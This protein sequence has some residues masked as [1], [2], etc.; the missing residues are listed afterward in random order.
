IDPVWPVG[1]P[2]LIVDDRAPQMADRDARVREA[3]ADLMRPF[4]LERGP[5][6]RAQLLR[7]D[8]DE[9]VLLVAMHHAISDEISVRVLIDQLARRYAGEAAPEPLAIQYADYAAWQR[10]WLTGAELDRQ[11]AYWTQHLGTEHD[12]LE[13]PTDRPRPA[14]MTGRG[15]ACP[16]A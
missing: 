15:A 12:V 13:L 8:A 5:L 16:I 11:L 6:W 3:F 7:L 9:H 4:D 14:V 1:A 10:T 2:A